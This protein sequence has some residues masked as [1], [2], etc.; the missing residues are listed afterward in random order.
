MKK[1]TLI[2]ISLLW[3]VHF[4]YSQQNPQTFPF[5][6]NTLPVDQRVNDLVARL[7][8]AEK[9]LQMQYTA[10]AIPRLGI[11]AYNWWN[12]CLHGVARNGVATVFPQA[13]GM[14]ATW[15]PELIQQEA[16]VISTEARAKHHDDARKEQ[17]G[18]YQGL[19]FW[20]PNIN[21]F[22]DPRWGRG[23]ETY[24]EDPFLTGRIGVAFVKGLQ[25]NDPHYFKVISTAKHFAVHSGP[26]ST[27]HEFDAWCSQRDLY[28]TYLPAFEAL[29]T[30][31]KAYSV[32]GAYNRLYGE[33]CC[34]STLLLEEILRRKWGFSGY[35]VSDCGAI[36]D[37]YKGH[38]LQPDSIKASVLGVNAGTDLTCGNEYT[39]LMAGVRNGW[40]SEK[41]IDQAVSRLFKARLLLGMF[42]PDSLVNYAQI[43]ITANDTKENRT[44]ALKVAQESMVLLKNDQNLLPLDK[45]KKKILVT[46]P[47]ADKMS[48]L[49][50]N[51]NGTPSKAYTVLEGIRDRKGT[52][53]SIQYTIGVYPPEEYKS[54]EDSLE[55]VRAVALAKK[56][57]V[58]LFVGGISPAL[59]GEEMNVPIEGFKGGDRTSLDI[60]KQ[61]QRLLELL[62][63]T[64]VP[65][66]LI[67]TNGSALSIP[68]AK[69]HLP[70]ILEAWYPGEEGGHAVADVLFG[71][72]NPSGRLPI[73]FYK[74]VND[75]PDFSDYSMQNRTYRYFKG[76]VLFPF[77]HGLSYANFR[78][79]SA[80]LIKQ[81]TDT[82]VI[83]VSLSNSS[84]VDGDEVVQI[85]AKKQ[86]SKF[87]QP[88]KRLV[89]F[90]RVSVPAGTSTTVQIPV[91]TKSLRIFNP[92][93]GEYTIEKGSYTFEVGASSGDIRTNVQVEL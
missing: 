92:T 6:N 9:V 70:A 57:D 38:G 15:N 49:L 87:E 43:P 37:I 61:Q 47:Y 75:L 86:D 27:R 45:S 30:E 76:E 50:G 17:R 63:A 42:D 19:T 83:H 93:S 58:V 73:T 25:G 4:S 67:L 68:W 22:R 62:H 54:Q 3:L 10:P 31:G 66:V 59:E 69:E 52:N 44:L 11:P 7:T 29:I 24:G 55:M 20:S 34:A 48:V 65:V 5:W 13:I 82:L 80:M 60:P 40:I 28:E 56:S 51:Y 23:Q 81:T 91:S 35:V 16:D 18:I 2:K 74:S 71:T 84:K 88:I 33:P 77:G 72:Y 78:Y 90:K 64:G 89:G 79:Q 12:E 85:Y 14:A 36:W 41:E 53:R 32:M 39:G 46:G 8:L 26:E 21:I 1:A